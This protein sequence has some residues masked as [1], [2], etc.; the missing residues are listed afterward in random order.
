M[1]IGGDG[2]DLVQWAKEGMHDEYRWTMFSAAVERVKTLLGMDEG[3]K[4]VPCR[5]DCSLSTYLKSY[6]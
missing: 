6:R 4:L 2:E 5:D 3:G 1:D